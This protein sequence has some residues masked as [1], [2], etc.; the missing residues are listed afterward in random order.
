MEKNNDL[1]NARTIKPITDKN[2]DIVQTL[3]KGKQKENKESENNVISSI[4]ELNDEDKKDKQMKTFNKKSIE[5]NT[6]PAIYIYDLIL[7]GDNETI[8]EQDIKAED[9]KIIT[10]REYSFLNDGE[11]NELDYDNSFAHDKRKFM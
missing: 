6:F 3:L 4:E 5:H 8:I 1:I 7:E 2:Y 10:K 11:I 9:S